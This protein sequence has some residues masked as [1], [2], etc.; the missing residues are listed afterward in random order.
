MNKFF[1]AIS[2]IIIIVFFTNIPISIAAS[3]IVLPI[4]PTQLKSSNIKILVY[5]SIA[6]TPDKKESALV[7]HY[8]VTPNVFDAQMKYL[9]DNGYHTI[10]LGILEQ[11]L[12]NGIVLPDKDIVLT[13][14]DGWKNQYTYGL[15]ILEKYGFTGTFGIITENMGKSKMTWDDIKNLNLKGFEIASHSVT[16]PFLTMISDKQ[17]VNEI[18]LS[19]KTLEEKIGKTIKT[20][21][22]PYYK[23]NANAMKVVK[24]AGYIGASAG[25]GKFNNTIEHIYELVSQEVVNNPNPFS[26]KRL[27]D[28]ETILDI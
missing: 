25:W 23:D 13:F 27:M 18:T 9:K 8:R 19:K 20:F 12:V 21:I 10:T 6:P 14:D 5:H 3:T 28:S 11:S 22:Y 7:L 17:L 24:D 15:P 16:H 2:N 4:K 26:N 1:L